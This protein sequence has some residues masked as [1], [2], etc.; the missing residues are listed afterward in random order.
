MIFSISGSN[1]ATEGSFSLLILLLMDRCTRLAHNTIR[2]LISIKINDHLWNEQERDNI[3]S[4]AID[5]YMS[6][7]RK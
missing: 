4:E 5:L 2:M 1:S 6:V 7:P 3:I